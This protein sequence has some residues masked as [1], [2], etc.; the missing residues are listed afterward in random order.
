VIASHAIVGRRKMAYRPGVSSRFAGEPP[1]ARRGINNKR[2]GAHRIEEIAHEGNRRG[3][4]GEAAD[5]DGE[6]NMAESHDEWGRTEK[7]LQEEGYG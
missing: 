7:Y 6:Q 1:W 3:G 5:C 4:A 2:E